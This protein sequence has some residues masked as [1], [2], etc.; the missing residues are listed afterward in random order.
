MTEEPNVLDAV[1]LIVRLVDAAP[2]GEEGTVDQLG[3]IRH[4]QRFTWLVRV[5]HRE[6]THERLLGP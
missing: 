3:V 4:R 2:E 1:A 5:V 6:M